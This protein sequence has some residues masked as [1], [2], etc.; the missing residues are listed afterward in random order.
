MKPGDV[1]RITSGPF[2]GMV[3]AV[4]RGPEARWYGSAVNVALARAELD[5][6]VGSLPWILDDAGRVEMTFA[7]RFVA[8][9]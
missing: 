1:V 5:R 6:R 8:L 4:I 3:G 2:A 9:A 7:A